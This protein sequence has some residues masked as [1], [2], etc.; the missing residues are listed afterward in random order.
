MN[1]KTKENRILLHRLAYFFKHFK[2]TQKKEIAGPVRD[3]LAETPEK[4]PRS[5]HLSKILDFMTR[6]VFKPMGAFGRAIP[7]NKQSPQMLK[8]RRERMEPPFMLLHTS[9]KRIQ[10]RYLGY[11]EPSRR[12]SR[13]RI[14]T[15]VSQAENDR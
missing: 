7:T 11:L 13:R 2:A 14:S 5:K 8:R 6:K 10:G 15:K 9:S 1:S 4:A 12:R 3:F